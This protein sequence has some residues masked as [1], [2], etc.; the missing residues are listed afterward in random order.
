MSAGSP[1]LHYS[2]CREEQSWM[3]GKC[4]PLWQSKYAPVPFHQTDPLHWC[5]SGIMGAH[6]VEAT[7]EKGFNYLLLL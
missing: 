7:R 6:I 3:L 5:Q 1:G 4:H 2:C